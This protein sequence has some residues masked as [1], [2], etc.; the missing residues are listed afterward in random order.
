MFQNL[1]MRKYTTLLLLAFFTISAFGQS[2][3]TV[4]LLSDEGYLKKSKQQ[5]TTAWILT[6]V[7]TTGLLTTLVADAGQAMG[8]AFTTVITLGTV[9]PEYKSYTGY[10]IASLAAV[11]G[12]VIYF[13]SAGKNKQRAR[14]LQTTFKIET[15]PV[16]QPKGIGQQAYPS[17]SLSLPL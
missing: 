2:S 9:E 12:G 11:T 10:Y 14:I 3:Q 17:L 7:G 15:A 13:V 5:K 1:F 8:G 6:T 16:L 4:P